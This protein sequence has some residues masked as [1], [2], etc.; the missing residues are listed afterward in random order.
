MAAED[1]SRDTQFVEQLEQEPDIDPTLLVDRLELE[2][3][4]AT[5]ADPEL[6]VTLE[7]GMDDPDGIDR[8]T[9]PRRRE[10]E[11]G[12]DLSAPLVAGGDDEELDSALG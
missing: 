8:P 5:F 3:A 9:A 12:W 1:I 11:E 4:G 10:D 2:E 6:L 7:G